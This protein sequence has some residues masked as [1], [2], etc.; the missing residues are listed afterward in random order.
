MPNFRT[1]DGTR[2]AYHVLGEGTPLLCVPGGPMHA[3]AY[4]GDLGGPRRQLILLDLRGTGDSERPADLATC[5]AD[6]LV[7]DVDALRGHLGLDTVDLL[8]HSAGAN[9]ALRYVEAHP[10]RVDRLVLVTPS[11]FAVGIDIPADARRE[12]IGRRVDEPWFESASQAFD[13]IAAGQGGPADWDAMAPCYY[14]RW[15]E[16]AKAH[17][18]AMQAQDDQTLAEAFRAEGAFD[19]PA[20]RAALATFSAPV[21]VVAGEADIAAPPKIIAE[22]TTLLPNAEF[23]IQPNAGHSPWLDDPEA[24]TATV[25][26]FLGA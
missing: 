6:R 26:D 22:Y 12:M 9:L 17:S 13:R 7:A 23:V 14:G 24:F 4:L 21:L 16:A 8:A 2:V 19:P 1:P 5:R 3:S 25:D 20:T 10:D 18:A 11:V 15:D